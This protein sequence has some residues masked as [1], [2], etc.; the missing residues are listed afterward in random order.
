MCSYIFSLSWFAPSCDSEAE[1]GYGHSWRSNK[2]TRGGPRI[3]PM[4]SMKS[5]KSP[6]V[7]DFLAILMGTMIIFMRILGILVADLVG[8]MA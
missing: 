8:D 7:D 3:G 5:M 2:P 6:Y 4:K 1:A